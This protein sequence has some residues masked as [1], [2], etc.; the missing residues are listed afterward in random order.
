MLITMVSFIM[1]LPC[2]HLEILL[3]PHACLTS[4]L[5]QNKND[6]IINHIIRTHTKEA[7]LEVKIGL[8]QQLHVIITCFITPF[9]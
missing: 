4:E 8:I 5:F 6:F 9:K 3:F 1:D 2:C 7:W